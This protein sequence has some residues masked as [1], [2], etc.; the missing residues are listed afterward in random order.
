MSLDLADM[1]IIRERLGR[2]DGGPTFYIE[3]NGKL[4]RLYDR[5]VIRRKV[6][7]Q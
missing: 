7:A 5:I 6:G 2:N 1:S 3:K 4:V